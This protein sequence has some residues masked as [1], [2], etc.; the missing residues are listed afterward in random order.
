MQEEDIVSTCLLGLVTAPLLYGIVTWV[1]LSAPLPNL[2]GQI[3]EEL[4]KIEKKVHEKGFEGNHSS[5][6]N[7]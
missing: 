2:G 3:Q 1:Y 7:H 4:V 6:K 5:V